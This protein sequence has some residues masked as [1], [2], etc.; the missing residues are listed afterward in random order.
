MRF[1]LIIISGVCAS[2]VLGQVSLSDLPAVAGSGPHSAGLVIDFNNGAQPDSF[3]WKYA[4]E[5]GLVSGAE[6]LIAVASVDPNLSVTYS[7][8]GSDGF[9]LNSIRYEYDGLLF[10]TANNYPTSSWG[11]YISGGEAG[12]LEI[13]NANGGLFPSDWAA[14]MVGASETSFGGLGRILQDGAWDYW[15]LGAYDTSTF[16]HLGTPSGTPLPAPIP[17][18]RATALAGIIGILVH[19]WRNSKNPGHRRFH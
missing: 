18:T 5:E 15:S 2:S 13:V 4:F 3:V 1:W 19:L 16:A 12:G 14:S 6:M 10:E 11:Y 7:G 17:E 8:D 9:F